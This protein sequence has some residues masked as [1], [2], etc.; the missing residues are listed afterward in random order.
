MKA[1]PKSGLPFRGPIVRIIGS[2]G[3]IWG[4]LKGE[5][6][7]SRYLI[8]S[9]GSSTGQWYKLLFLQALQ[10]ACWAPTVNPEVEFILRPSPH[11][12]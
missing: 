9:E 7:M 3:L 12:R 1:F 5:A 11:L 2:W 4:S 6:T 8:F 10:Y